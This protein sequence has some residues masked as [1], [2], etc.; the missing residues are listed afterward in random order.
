[1][2]IN[3]YHRG[4]P[5]PKPF[6]FRLSAKSEHEALVWAQLEYV[7]ADDLNYEELRNDTEK[8]QQILHE[9]GEPMT[10]EKIRN[11][12]GI[13]NDRCSKVINHMLQQGT[14]KEIPEGRAK[15]IWFRELDDIS[16]AGAERERYGN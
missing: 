11:A 8:I 5:Q 13:R 4:A 16:G 1:V 9:N 2:E 15:L 10:R 6:V 14:L 3:I 7:S 12:A